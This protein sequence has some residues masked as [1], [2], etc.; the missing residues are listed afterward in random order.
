MTI[1]TQESY[2]K[3][4][5]NTAQ[6]GWHVLWTHSNYERSVYEQLN[7]KHY[8]V[9]FARVDQWVVNNKGK[10]LTRVPMFRSYLFIHHAIG[11]HDYIDICK[12]KGLVRILGDRWD[13]LARIPDQEIESI[14]AVCASGCPVRSYPYLNTGDKVRVTRGCLRDTEGILLRNDDQTGLLVIS[15]PLLNRSVSIKVNCT[16]VVPL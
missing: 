13:K 5:C 8:D 1:V 16:D 12:T 6:A 3:D 2:Q 9:F 11:K 10:H 15:V 4:A 14:K 7:A